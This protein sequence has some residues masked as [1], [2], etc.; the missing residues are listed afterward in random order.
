MIGVETRIT[1]TAR[2]LP[3]A[4]AGRDFADLVELHRAEL[5]AH[6][7]RMLGSVHDADDAVQETMLRAWRGAVGLRED[8]SARSW[9]YA[10]ATNVCLT[11]LGRRSKRVLPHDFGPPAE[12]HT[13][14]GAPVAE[15]V[16]LEPYPD[17][18]F[19][20]P[21]G[22]PHRKPATS[23]GRES[24]WRSSPRSSIWAPASARC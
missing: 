10:I 15:S 12:Q 23:S 11:E 5:H 7:Y 16:W 6:C 21:A 8:R 24:S 22:R 20:L 18:S 13:P 19:G 3:A 2:E 9:L 17:E 1:L 14:P 4:R